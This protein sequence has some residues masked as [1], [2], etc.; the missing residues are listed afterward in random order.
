[1]KV[2]NLTFCGYVIS[3][4]NLKCTEILETSHF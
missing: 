4:G 2:Y 3:G 1:M